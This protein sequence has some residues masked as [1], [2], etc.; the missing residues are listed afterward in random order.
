MIRHLHQKGLSNGQL[1][2]RFHQDRSTISRII[3]YKT[4][5]NIK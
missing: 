4:Y 5:R 2:I 3:N 1:A